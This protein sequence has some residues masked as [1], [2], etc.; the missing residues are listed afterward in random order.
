MRIRPY[1]EKEDIGG[2]IRLCD[3]KGYMGGRYPPI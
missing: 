3:Q 1:T 2:Y